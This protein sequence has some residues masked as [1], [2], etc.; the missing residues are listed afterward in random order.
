MLRSNKTVKV[1]E[2]LVSVTEQFLPSRVIYWSA[3]ERNKN[4]RNA[5]LCTAQQY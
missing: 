3:S 5:S 2:I 1:I 4:C